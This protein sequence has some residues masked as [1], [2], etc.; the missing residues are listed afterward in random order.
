MN[1]NTLLNTLPPIE[2]LVGLAV[3]DG[4]TQIHYIPAIAGKL[5]SLRVYNALAEA[6]HGRLDRTSA[7]QGI[8]LFAEHSEDAKQH[9]G[10]HPNIDLLFQIIE[11]D[12]HYQ[13]VPQK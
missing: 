2:D 10:K 3:M 13:L 7:Q 9:P 1:F 12:L 11:Q 6:F 4:E 8:Q 5:G